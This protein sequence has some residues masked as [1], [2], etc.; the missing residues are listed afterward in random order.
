[1]DSYI[2][3]M[4]CRL[5]FVVFT[6]WTLLNRKERL[7]FQHCTT[8]MYATHHNKEIYGS[9]PGEGKG[10]GG[11]HVNIFGAKSA[12]QCEHCHIQSSVAHPTICSLAAVAAVSPSGP[13]HHWY[14]IYTAILAVVYEHYE[15]ND[16]V[17]HCRVM[18]KEWYTVL[19]SRV[20]PNW[21]G[22]LTP[23]HFV[24][25]AHNDDRMW[26]VRMAIHLPDIRRISRTLVRFTTRTDF[27]G[28][29]LPAATL[30]ERFMSYWLAV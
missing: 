14:N 29:D 11:F 27:I 23:R 9:Q 2:V 25:S 16:T 18:S 26:P 24:A 4:G 20:R 5:N 3:N 30:D 21:A 22:L 13:A 1:M 8:T 28:S 12:I 7:E 10:G 15:V 17:T 6:I 19:A